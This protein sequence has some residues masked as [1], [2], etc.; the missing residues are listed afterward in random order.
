MIWV[1]LGGGILL[2]SYLFYLLRYPALPRSTLKKIPGISLSTTASRLLV[3]SPHP[4]DETLSA[5]GLIQRT[6]SNGGEV[7]VVI[8]TDG[9]KW[10]K[11]LIRQREVS[12][13]M[14]I[15]GLPSDQLIFWPFGDGRLQDN[16]A[17]TEALSQ[18][19]EDFL[20]TVIVTTD[21]LDTHKDHQAL[22]LVTNRLITHYPTI[23]LLTTLIHYHRFPRPIGLRPTAALLPPGCLFSEL[24]WQQLSLTPTEQST[25][26][27]AINC[28]TSQL[29]TWF[30]RGLMFSF[31][32][33]NELFI[34]RQVA[35]KN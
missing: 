17:L 16:S 6:L 11:K 10:G 27:T 19:I 14:S 20:P 26:A 15:C 3:L 22:G 30:L 32:R 13:A 34:C 24:T 29:K 18:E 4:D 9:D 28:F 35:T 1:G 7:R 2:A 8:V 5:A 23:G 25:K 12:Q 21:L 31:N 33:P